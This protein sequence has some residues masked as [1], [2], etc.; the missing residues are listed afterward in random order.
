MDRNS[1]DGACKVIGWSL[2]NLL[3]VPSNQYIKKITKLHEFLNDRQLKKII[4]P[5]ILKLL[6]KS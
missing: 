3:S 1:E 2:G 5:V 6:I 4:N